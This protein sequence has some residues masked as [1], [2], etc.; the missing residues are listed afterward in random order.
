MRA[1]SLGSISGAPVKYA[2]EAVLEPYGASSTTTPTVGVL[3]PLEL[4][5]PRIEILASPN[6]VVVRLKPGTRV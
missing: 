3:T 6:P 5:K 2:P 4:I 1:R